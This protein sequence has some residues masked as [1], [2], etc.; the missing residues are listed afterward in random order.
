MAQYMVY[1]VSEMYIQVDKKRKNH[2]KKRLFSKKMWED[3]AEVGDSG[4]VGC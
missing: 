4:R 3:V 2:L 1:K